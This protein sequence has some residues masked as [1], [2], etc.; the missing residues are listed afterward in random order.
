LKRGSVLAH[1]FM[2]FGAGASADAG[3]PLAKKFVGRIE[4]HLQSLRSPTKEAALQEFAAIRAFVENRLGA[5]PGLEPIF[6]CVDDALESRF[7]RVPATYPPSRA[8]E[9]IHYE[10]KRVIQTECVVRDTRG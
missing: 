2:L 7:E 5:E 8:V 4:E 3:V 1:S 9:R 6:E 10:I